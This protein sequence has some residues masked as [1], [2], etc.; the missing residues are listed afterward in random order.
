VS[1]DFDCIS[2]ADIY[3]DF[4][5][6]DNLTVLDEM[7]DETVIKSLSISEIPD[8][9]RIFFDYETG[10]LAM[11][12]EDPICSLA[13][14][15][16]DERRS[17]ESPFVFAFPELNSCRLYNK[18]AFG[19]VRHVASHNEGEFF[20]TRLFQRK[21]LGFVDLKDNKMSQ[22]GIFNFFNNANAF[23]SLIF[24]IYF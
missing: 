18:N 6:E 4:R 1:V 7:S 24:Y 5:G 22:A 20:K 13:V 14:V 2:K 21:E 11:C 16:T 8:H 17:D 12:H 15:V 23:P 9:F 10:C 19:Y 3:T